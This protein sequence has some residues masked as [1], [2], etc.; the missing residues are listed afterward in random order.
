MLDAPG[1]SSGLAGTSEFSFSY[2]K[3]LTKGQVVFVENVLNLRHSSQ[4]ARFL[5]PPIDC[6]GLDC[7]FGISSAAPSEQNIGPPFIAKAMLSND[8]GTGLCSANKLFHGG[9][10]AA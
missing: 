8:W 3:R 9:V 6:C 1:A 5:D 10:L 2:R 4:A 7:P